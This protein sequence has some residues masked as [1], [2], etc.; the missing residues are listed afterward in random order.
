LKIT[1]FNYELLVTNISINADIP[2]EIAE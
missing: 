1:I 2:T